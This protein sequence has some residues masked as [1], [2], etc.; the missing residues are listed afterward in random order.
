MDAGDA[1]IAH[2][3]PAE[4]MKPSE[5][6]LD[7]PPMLAESLLG[8]DAASGDS[9]SDVPLAASKAAFLRVI[10]LVGM[11]F[12]RS[13]TWKSTFAAKGWDCIQ[14][15]L[16]HLGVM[17]IPRRNHG[18]EGSPIRIDDDVMLG[19]WTSSIYRTWAC[20]FAP[21]FAWI[22]EESK[23]ARSQLMRSA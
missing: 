12:L 3:K 11:N 22:L 2:L 18:G 23:A 6:S 15:G 16:E 21:L 8:F 1:L 4:S 7:D 19:P 14:Q 13:A 9:R 5:G 10:P 17:G 20:F